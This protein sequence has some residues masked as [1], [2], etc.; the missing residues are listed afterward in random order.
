MKATKRLD[1]R[2]DEVSAQVAGQTTG[3]SQTRGPREERRV[4]GKGSSVGLHAV[5]GIHRTSL[6]RSPKA[7]RRGA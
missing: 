6:W 5:G 7:A 1:E 4:W 2:A 3:Q